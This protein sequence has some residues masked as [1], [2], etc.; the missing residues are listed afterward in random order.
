MSEKC[1]FH[2]IQFSL[3]VAQLGLLTRCRS[4]RYHGHF[5]HN[6]HHLHSSLDPPEQISFAMQKN[7]AYL[8]FGFAAR[9]RSQAHCFSLLR[10]GERLSGGH[11][12]KFEKRIFF[13]GQEEDCRKGS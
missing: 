5:L 1:I 2:Y 6:S 10:D 12:A 11:A 3:V 8:Q 13:D 9:P 7:P 4:L